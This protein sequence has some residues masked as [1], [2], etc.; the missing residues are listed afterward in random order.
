MYIEKFEKNSSGPIVTVTMNYDEVMA[1]CNAVYAY[2]KDTIVNNRH[3]EAYMQKMKETFAEMSFV[4]DV[5]KHGMVQEDTVQF[6]KEVGYN[7]VLK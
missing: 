2:T 3:D 7:D 6:F 5:V 1:L 4:K